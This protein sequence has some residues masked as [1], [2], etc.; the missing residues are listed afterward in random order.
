MPVNQLTINKNGFNQ[1]E[2]P[3]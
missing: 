1:S 2:T 3:G